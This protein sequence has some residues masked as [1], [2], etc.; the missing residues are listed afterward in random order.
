MLNQV[1]GLKQQLVLDEEMALI[2]TMA[3]FPGLLEDISV[4]LEPH[5]LT[6]FLAE[7]AQQ[8][9]I[10][11]IKYTFDVEKNIQRF[12][13]KIKHTFAVGKKHKVL[14]LRLLNPLR[15]NKYES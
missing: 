5:R 2:R 1:N 12:L 11:K 6:Y 9:P 14:F 13:L 15:G 3:Q 8:R 4:S 7:L 10:C